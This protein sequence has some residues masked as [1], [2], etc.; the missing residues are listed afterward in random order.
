LSGRQRKGL[1]PVR[2]ADGNL[3]TEDADKAQAF[4]KAFFPK[5]GMMCDVDQTWDPEPRPTREFPAFTEHELGKQLAAT[6]NTSA[7]GSSGH[8]YRILKWAYECVP[9]RFTRLFTACVRWGYHPISWCKAVNVVVPK[10]GKKDKAAPRSYCPIALLECASKWLEKLVNERMQ[11]ECG[12]FGLILTNQFGCRQKSSTLD[13]GLSMTH[14]IETA[15]T[16]G[17]TAS[18]LTFNISGFFDRVNHDRLCRVV[19]KMGFNAGLV[20]WLRSWLSDRRV[21][22]RLDGRLTPE[23]DCSVGVPQGS[24]LSPIL[25]AIYTAWIADALKGQTNASLCFYVD[26]GALAAFSPTLTA[27]VRTIEQNF[28][29]VVSRLHD[30]G[31]PVDKGKCDAMHF[32]RKRG[33]G[34]PAFCPEMPNGEKLHVTAQ[35]NMHWLGFFF[36]RQ[37]LWTQHVDIMCN[38]A[39]SKVHGLKILGNSVKGMRLDNRRQLF[40]T[41]IIPVLTYGVPLWYRGA[42]KRQGKL[43]QKMQRVQNAA[44]KSMLGAFRT[45]PV[46]AMEHIASII[47][48]RLRIERLMARAAVCLRTLPVL[49]QPLMRMPD[50][51]HPP[52]EPRQAI[53]VAAPRPIKARTAASKR[54]AAEPKTQ[55]HRLAAKAQVSG[56][57]DERVVPFSVAPWETDLSQVWD[58]QYNMDA[59]GPHDKYERLEQHKWNCEW[60]ARHPKELAIYTDGSRHAVRV[61]LPAR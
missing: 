49:L 55:L 56:R 36:D 52:G 8:N 60:S 10:P 14:N 51:W 32:T 12:T 3:V 44:L 17:M 24:P 11:Y 5:A 2:A 4:F 34:S 20:T 41:I 61:A 58:R 15:W 19:E 33:L 48:M 50:A 46:R 53:P 47:P 29:L 43:V 9:E 22:F 42:D 13:A 6:S 27:D 45:S 38:R 40:N 16:R 35:K 1:G 25:L 21:Q 23:V 37:L 31:M 28:K 57:A 26:D 7:P 59:K 30:V 54:R 39:M 18:V